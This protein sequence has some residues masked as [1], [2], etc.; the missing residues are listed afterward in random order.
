MGDRVIERLHRLALQ[1]AA[2][3][4]N[5]A[6]N[7]DRQANAGVLEQLVDG[8]Q[9]R[10]HD[11]GVEGRFRQQQ[12]HTAGQQ[13][14]RLFVVSIDHLIEGDAAVTGVL[15]INTHRQRP[16]RWPD[17]AG[18]KAWLIRL[19]A[20]QVVGGPAGDLGSRFVDCEDVVCQVI[21]RQ[22]DARGVEGVRLDEVGAGFQIGAVNLL[23]DTRLRQ[24]EQIV[25]AAQVLGMRAEALAA[26]VGLA[27]PIGLDHGAHRPVQDED[28]PLEQ[29]FEQ[30]V[31]S[32]VCGLAHD[33]A[34]PRTTDNAQLSYSV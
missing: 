24:A 20:R 33:G 27:Q 1:R 17:A 21:V 32:G 31:G 23:D 26:K 16:I 15:D 6:G 9:R 28:A 18:N 7:H 10:L 8:E 13:S 3:F 30:T 19:A 29:F 11:E 22:A 5:G 4:E 25:A 34:V 2:G 12:V 14:L